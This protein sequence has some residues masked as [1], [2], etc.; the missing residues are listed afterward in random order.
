MGKIKTA[1]DKVGGDAVVTHKI[2]VA[3]VAY[4]VILAVY[5]DVGEHNKAAV[6][7]AVGIVFCTVVTDQ[8]ADKIQRKPRMLSPQDRDAAGQVEV[9]FQG[10]GGRDLKMFDVHCL[11]SLK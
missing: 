8:L 3:D 6:V 10:L 7:V 11:F 2:G 1:G 5:L 4:V 9:E